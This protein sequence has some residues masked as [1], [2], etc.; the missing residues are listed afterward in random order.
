METRM[1]ITFFD[2]HTKVFVYRDDY[3]DFKITDGVL[4][5]YH[6]TLPIAIYAKGAWKSVEFNR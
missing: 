3:T 4:S 1:V 6:N 5:I 2:G